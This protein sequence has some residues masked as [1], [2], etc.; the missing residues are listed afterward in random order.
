MHFRAA[1][2]AILQRSFNWLLMCSL[3]F[4]AY[5][6]EIKT[7]CPHLGGSEVFIKRLVFH[8]TR[9][10]FLSWDLRNKVSVAVTNSYFRFLKQNRIF[11]HALKPTLVNDLSNYSY[12]VHVTFQKREQNLK[13][14]VG[15][16]VFQ[17]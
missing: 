9:Y 5:Q 8:D 4:M 2:R 1:K 17:V 14:K 3:L 13:E 11:I 6:F 16:W 12:N 10:I 15:S 7:K